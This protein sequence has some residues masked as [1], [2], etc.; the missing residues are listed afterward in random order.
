MN[1]CPWSSSRVVLLV[2]VSVRQVSRHLSIMFA[3]RKRFL[4]VAVD[5]HNNGSKDILEI[6][7]FETKTRFP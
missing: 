4:V 1:S 5:L 2:P 6:V 3:L 7:L